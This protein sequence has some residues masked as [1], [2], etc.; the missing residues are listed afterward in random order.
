M[1]CWRQT[2]VGNSRLISC[3]SGNRKKT[4]RTPKIDRSGQN[5]GVFITCRLTANVVKSLAVS[6]ENPQRCTAAVQMC[7]R[8]VRLKLQIAQRDVCLYFDISY[9]LNRLCL[10]IKLI[11]L[12]VACE[13]KRKIWKMF[14]W[15][16]IIFSIQ[17]YVSS[18]RW[19]ATNLYINTTEIWRSRLE[20]IDSSRDCRDF[21]HWPGGLGILAVGPLT[22]I[23]GKIRALRLTNEIHTEL[24]NDILLKIT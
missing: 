11:K 24:Y 17:A 18:V 4:C 5:V 13:T 9:W 2:L 20:D 3:N 1:P 21:H 12:V 19:L 22:E 6:T 15:L 7:N 8:I 16:P 23:A 14:Q 10:L